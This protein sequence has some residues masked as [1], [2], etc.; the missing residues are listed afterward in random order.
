MKKAILI[1]AALSGATALFAQQ[2]PQYNLYQFNPLVIN[3]AYAGARDGLSAAA[4]VRQQW[5]GVDGAPRT[6]CLSGHAPIAGKNIGVGVTIV[7]DVMGPRNVFSAY[8]NFAY[9]LKLSSKS[10]LSFGINAGYNMYQ[11]NFNKIKFDINEGVPSEFLSNQ[12]KGTLDMNGGLFF[13]TT[14]FFAGLSATHLNMPNVYTY[15]NKNAGQYVYKVLPH[16]FL[17]L[18]K[19]FIINSNLVF[20]PTILVKQVNNQNSTDINLNFFIHKKLWAGVFYRAGYGPGG[21]LQYYI[22]NN[23]RVAYSYDTG[24]GVAT[25][26]GGSHEVMLGYDFA[27]TARAKMVNPRFL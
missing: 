19:S 10:R 5:T 27:P 14:G 21:L 16:I 25:R 24:L 6:A 23:F 11:F 8:G 15:D 17:T 4:T 2:D 12:N 9:I 1:S 26:L 3:P 20:A 7:N 18:G 13:R 22:S